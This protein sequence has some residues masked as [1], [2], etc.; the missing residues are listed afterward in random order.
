[1]C[2]VL[3]GQPFKVASHEHRPQLVL[4]GNVELIAAWIIPFGDFP[5]TWPAGGL[6]LSLFG[7]AAQGTLGISGHRAPKR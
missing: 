4:V 6:Y 3:G 2:T 5:D 1:M 7:S